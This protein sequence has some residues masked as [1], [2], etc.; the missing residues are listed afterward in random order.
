MTIAALILASIA[1][2]VSL[3]TLGLVLAPHLMRTPSEKAETAPQTNENAFVEE[4]INERR[5][6]VMEENKAFE[7]LMSYNVDKA[8][9]RTEVTNE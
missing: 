6:R 8:Y 2:G 1:C 9:G 5:R 3:F 7:E 4:D